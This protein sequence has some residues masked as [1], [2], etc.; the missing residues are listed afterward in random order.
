MADN[1]IIDYI[2]KERKHG[3]LDEVINNALVQQEWPETAISAAF[4]QMA[5]EVDEKRERTPW[6]LRIFLGR[7]NRLEFFFGIFLL[8]IVFMSAL[9]LTSQI[10]TLDAYSPLGYLLAVFFGS[11]LIMRRIND[12]GL[13][14]NPMIV[15]IMMISFFIISP[16]LILF[17][18]YQEGSPN[19]NED[20]HPTPKSPAI[21]LTNLFLSKR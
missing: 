15:T 10:S 13:R 20:G 2:R 3:T 17:L 7:I 14:R 12:T 16:L 1:Q 11:S 6:I 19:A 5:V 18:L 21:S 9:A 8:V 4:N